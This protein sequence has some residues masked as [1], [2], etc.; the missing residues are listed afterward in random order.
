M[1]KLFWLFQMDRVARIRHDRQ[2]CV[3]QQL[4]HLPGYGS[5]LTV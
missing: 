2:L 4:G 5:E 3:W 1:V